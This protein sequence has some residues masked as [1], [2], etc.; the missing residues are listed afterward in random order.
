MLEFISVQSRGGEIVHRH[1]ARQ[2]AKYSQH[3]VNK[4]IFTENSI[5]KYF[6]THLDK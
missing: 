6:Y 1:E 3:I 4:S 2:F 5:F